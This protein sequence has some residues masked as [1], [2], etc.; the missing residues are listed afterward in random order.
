MTA[1]RSNRIAQAAGFVHSV[2]DLRDLFD[3]DFPGSQTLRVLELVIA[4]P[5]SIYP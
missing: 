5:T 2:E 1:E 4:L 3:L